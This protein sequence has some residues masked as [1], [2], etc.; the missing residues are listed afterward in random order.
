MREKDKQEADGPCVK[1]AMPNSGIRC[2]FKMLLHNLKA[3]E[4]SEISTKKR[5]RQFILV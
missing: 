5:M 2:S 1:L 3:T 4:K